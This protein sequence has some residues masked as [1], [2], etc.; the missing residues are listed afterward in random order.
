MIVKYLD[1]DV[2]GFIDNVRQVVNKD[3]DTDALIRQYDEEPSRRDIASEN[4][5]VRPGEDEVIMS[6]KAFVVATESLEDVP[7]NAHTL[8]FLEPGLLRDNMPAAV[9]IL[10]V[11]DYKEYDTIILVTNQK[12]YLMNDKGQTIERLV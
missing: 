10:C 5:P 6:N 12:C 4:V 9:I 8:N 3:I 7:G 11:E 1:G 2:W